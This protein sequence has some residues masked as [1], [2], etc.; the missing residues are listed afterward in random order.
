[1]RIQII[2]K[3]RVGFSFYLFLKEKGY[4]VRIYSRRLGGDIS[5]YGDILFIATKDKEIR[6]VSE[7]FRDLDYRVFAHFSG[8]FLS[9]ILPEDKERASFHPLQAFNSPDPNLWKSI[10]VVCEGTDKALET[11]KRFAESLGLKFKYIS[12]E[13]KVIY[14]AAAVILSN[15]VYSPLICADRIFRNLGIDKEDYSKLLRTSIDNFISKGEKGLTGPIVRGDMETINMHLKTLKGDAREIY[16][17]LTDFIL[18]IKSKD[19]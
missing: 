16:K 17:C 13:N 1:M 11:L 14:H 8:A 7:R 5:P 3:G 4:D 19:A 9:D 12:P 2:G 18:R 15:L 10:T 6:R